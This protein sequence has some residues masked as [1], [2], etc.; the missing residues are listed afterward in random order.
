MRGRPQTS[1]ASKRTRPPAAAPP[2]T[3][4]KRSRSADDACYH[5]PAFPHGPPVHC[6][7]PDLYCSDSGPREPGF[8]WTDPCCGRFGLC[9]DGP[10]PGGFRGG[11]HATEPCGCAQSGQGGGGQWPGA[12]QGDGVRHWPGAGLGDGGRWG[13]GLWDGALRT[14]SQPEWHSQGGRMLHDF[15]LQ[16]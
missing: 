16:V 2:G 12:G 13:V 11:G 1:T 15:R 10:G 8:T 4:V 14:A 7:D 9:Q 5:Q 3:S 6:S